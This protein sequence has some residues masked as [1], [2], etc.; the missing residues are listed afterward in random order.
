[1][2]AVAVGWGEKSFGPQAFC[3]RHDCGPDGLEADSDGCNQDGQQ[4]R[5]EEYKRADA[6]AIGILL[7]P[8]LQEVEGDGRCNKTADDDEQD[9]VFC[10][11]KEYLRDRCAQYLTDADLFCAL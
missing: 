9:K 1:M 3:R 2:A 8:V 5:Q 7:E 4:G 6:D 10:E 11:H